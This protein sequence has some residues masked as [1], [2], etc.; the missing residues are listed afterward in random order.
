LLISIYLKNKV[1]Q[2]ILDNN[3]KILP[4]CLIISKD[5]NYIYCISLI[6]F[7]VPFDYKKDIEIKY[8][9]IYQKMK[10]DDINF[11]AANPERYADRLY[12]FFKNQLLT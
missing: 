4:P 5:S 1:P 8:K 7:L 9:T 11:S 10:N 3:N 2:L 12:E 6:D